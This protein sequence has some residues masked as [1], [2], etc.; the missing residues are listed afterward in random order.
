[1]VLEVTAIIAKT[2]SLSIALVIEWSD[3]VLFYRSR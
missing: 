3:Y 2:V 1:M